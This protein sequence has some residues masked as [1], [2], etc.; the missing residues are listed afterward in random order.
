MKNIISF[1]LCLLWTMGLFAQNSNRTLI[2]IA[3]E[4]VSVDDFLNIYNKNR[5]VGEQLDPKTIDEYID[6]YVNF[7]LKVKEAESLGMDTIPEFVK[8]LAGYRKQLATPY[9]VD[10]KVGEQLIREA[11]DRLQT[12]IR[13]SHILI[14]VAEDAQPDDTLRAYNKILSLRKELNEGAIFSVVAKQNSQDPSVKDN[15]GDLGYFS[16]LYMVYPFENAAY[17]TPIGEISEIVRTR[18]G[19]HLLKVT[20]RRKSRGEV[21]TAHIMVKFNKESNQRTEADFLSSK[22]KIDDIYQKILNENADFSEM[23]KQYSDDK[24]TALSGGQL[25]WFGSNKMVESFENAAFGLQAVG[26]I[27]MPIYTPYGWHI[28][29]LLDRKSLGTF[30]EEKMD[31]TKRVE[32]DSRAHL[33][34]SSLVDRLKR[35]YGYQLN[36]RALSDLKQ[37]TQLTSGTWTFNKPL[38]SYRKTLFSLS[39]ENYTQA[40]FASFLLAE[41]ITDQKGASKSS[42]FDNLFTKW[43]EDQVLAYEDAHLEEKYN[44]FRLLMSEYRDGILLYELTDDKIWSKAVK[45]TSGLKAFY[46]K[47]LQNYLWDTRLKATIINCAN[48]KIANRVSKYLKK[49]KGN[50]DKL[51]TKINKSSSLNMVLESGIYLRGENNFIDQVDWK[52]GVSDFISDQKNVK[53]VL[54]EE[55][56]APSPK[57][58]KEVKGQVIS[59]YQEFLQ[60]QWVKELKGK[61]EVTVHHNVL[62]LLKSN[63][64]DELIVAPAENELP[65]YS[66]RF[67]QAFRAALNDLGSSKNN[68]F[69]WNGK[70][71]TTQLKS[72]S[73]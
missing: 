21:K 64:L 52:V 28:I 26:D 53:I 61:Y 49:K 17:N 2:S 12:E 41:P 25:P 48:E 32:K 29:K 1:I 71:F 8:E 54:V 57:E 30:D 37:N 6:L 63:R 47:N 67:G 44:D 20:D 46:D 15:A 50:I 66:G 51:Q 72:T 39:D 22:K 4:E 35:E 5:Q 11:Y 65:T 24:G 14:S 19:Y 16:A 3:D 42:Y 62:N 38:E 9:L 18:F 60:G 31:I 7:K 68:L 33:K 43:I 45:D 34:R 13:A 10:T 58:L 69:L 55:V 23:A 59:D 56:L 27:T 70:T 73:E 40:E 36:L